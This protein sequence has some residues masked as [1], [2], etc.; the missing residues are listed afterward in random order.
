MLH[1][2][3][4]IV[5]IAV[6]F[7]SCSEKDVIVPPF[8][9]PESNRVVLIEELT[10]VRCPNCPSGAA[11]LEDL[12]ALYEGKLVIMA[13]HGDFDTEPMAQSKY[14]FRTE[15][16]RALENYLR[17]FWGKPSIAVNR[18]GDE[19]EMAFI[20]IN[21]WAGII[22]A[23]LA[24]PHQMN[25]ELNTEF[26]P[27]TRKLTIHVG[28]L[29]L[30]DLTGNFNLS[31]A[32]TESNIIDAQVNQTVIIPDYTHK[33]VMRKMLTDYKG[34]QISTGFK[35][36]QVVNKSFEYTLPVTEGLWIP[37]NCEVVAFVNKIDGNKKE[38]LQAAHAKVVH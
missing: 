22:E 37:E 4:L 13:V 26:D 17:P 38:V 25:I 33:H 12:D 9:A 28:C 5:F 6:F 27:S 11:M 7:I 29:P 31:V 20:G 15:E 18:V 1:K 3:F 19:E 2:Y 35:A 16:S 21:R 32:I 14:D 24:K 36:N 8:T 10:G 30:Q 34:D 23:E